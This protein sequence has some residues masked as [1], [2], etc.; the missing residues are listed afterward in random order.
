MK[1]GEKIKQL[2]TERGITQET[3]ATHLNIS[4]QAISKWE[5]GTALPDIALV[6]AIVKFFGITPNDIFE[7]GNEL[8]QKCATVGV[9][10][11]YHA[12]DENI[13]IKHHVFRMYL[14]NA[15]G[16]SAMNKLLD[17]GWMVKEMQALAEDEACY[18]V[19]V[20]EKREEKG[21]HKE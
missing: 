16:P 3:L 11:I 8:V 7:I 4:P 6:P 18:A 17:D 14:G 5:N 2:R 9:G 15:D 10:A 1:I 21:E 19:F 20:L 13:T 12:H